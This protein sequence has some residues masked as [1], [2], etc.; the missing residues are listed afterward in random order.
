MYWGRLGDRYTHLG[1][2]K[3]LFKFSLYIYT[4]ESSNQWFHN[5]SNYFEMA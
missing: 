4:S 5:V 3:T 1:T 2:Q